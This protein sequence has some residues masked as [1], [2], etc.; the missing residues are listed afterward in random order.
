[1]PGAH[2]VNVRRATVT[3]IWDPIRTTIRTTN[4]EFFRQCESSG[5][6]VSMAVINRSLNQLRSRRTAC[7]CGLCGET[8]AKAR[9]DRV[10]RT[11]SIG[12][13]SVIATRARM[14]AL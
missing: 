5:Q 6:L 3:K 7:K 4:V 11:A 2:Q 8:V 9:A 10:H 1:M 13:R 14:T 12:Q